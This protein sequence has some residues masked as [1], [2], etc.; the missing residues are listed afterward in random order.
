MGDVYLDIDGWNFPPSFC[1]SHLTLASEVVVVNPDLDLLVWT[2]SLDSIDTC[3]VVY[4]FLSMLGVRLVGVNR[5][6]RHL[7]LHLDLSLAFVSWED[8]Y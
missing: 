7:F 4:A 3:K 5:F 2:H 6:G 1:T 8:S